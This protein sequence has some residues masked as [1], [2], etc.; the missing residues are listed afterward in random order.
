[1]GDKGIG[2]GRNRGDCENLSDCTQSHSTYSAEIFQTKPT[3]LLIME[4]LKSDE[5]VRLEAAT[6]YEDNRRRIKTELTMDLEEQV[7]T[8]IIDD[9]QYADFTSF[10]ELETE[11]IQYHAETG[12]DV[13]FSI[14]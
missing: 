10:V 2:V 5:Q 3:G 6:E 9:I 11:L 8:W 4:F 1:M 7:V 12:H 13:E 14:S